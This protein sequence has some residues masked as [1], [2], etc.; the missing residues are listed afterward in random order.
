MIFPLLFRHTNTT[1]IT[2]V[3]LMPFIRFNPFKYFFIKF[4]FDFSYVFSNN[5]KHNIE[6]LDR[7]KTL[8]NGEVVDI[9]IPTANSNRRVYSRTV[10]DS[11]IQ[12]INNLQMSFV[13]ALGGNIY[14]TDKLLML[15]SFSYFKALNNMSEFGEN[16]RIDAWR[17]NLELKYNF[18][19]SNKI[20]KQKNRKVIN[21][22]QHPRNP[23][24]TR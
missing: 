19:T 4:G 11:E 18:A 13:P 24:T 7:R 20:Y 12:D 8:P 15:P 22:K 5:V 3:G 1:S 2:T 23:R 14:F 16:F 17:I 9:F 6:L 21:D 10:Q